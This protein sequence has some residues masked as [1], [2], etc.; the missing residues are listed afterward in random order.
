MK[1]LSGYD[2][3]MENFMLKL[4]NVKDIKN[5]KIVDLTI[6][7]DGKII[8]EEVCDIEKTKGVVIKLLNSD[9]VISDDDEIILTQKSK[10]V[11]EE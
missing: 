7:E 8:K 2:V 11:D 10:E 6:L 1:N 9:D 4:K 5:N 3:F